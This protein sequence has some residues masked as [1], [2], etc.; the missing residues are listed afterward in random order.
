MASSCILRGALVRVARQP[1]RPGTTHGEAP[2]HRGLRGGAKESE[3]G[4]HE[5]GVA[6]LALAPLGREY[7]DGADLPP[8]TRQRQRR[9]PQVGPIE[10]LERLVL[11]LLRH[12]DEGHSLVHTHEPA[13]RSLQRPG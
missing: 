2:G 7:D 6:T 3:D 12:I 4:L 9:E 10:W 8:R 11:E 5:I 13:D 1:E